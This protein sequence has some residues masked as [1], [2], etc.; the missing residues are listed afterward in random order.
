MSAV[1]SR[2]MLS[3]VIVSRFGKEEGSAAA[4]AGGGAAAGD[5]SCAAS[6]IVDAC[7]I[8]KEAAEREGRAFAHCRRRSKGV[9]LSGREGA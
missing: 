2:S 3:R 5:A 6:R 4:A 1:V 8:A 7:R 9:G